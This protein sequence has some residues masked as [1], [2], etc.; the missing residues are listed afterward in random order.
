MTCTRAC[1]RVC[2]RSPTCRFAQEG[3]FDIALRY[4]A[5]IAEMYYMDEDYDMAAEHFDRAAL[6]CAEVYGEEV[7][8]TA[9]L[10]AEAVC[11]CIAFPLHVRAVKEDDH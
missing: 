10:R 11:W 8:R 6:Y 3:R 5:K 4:Q 1:V 9:R 7:Q 2:V